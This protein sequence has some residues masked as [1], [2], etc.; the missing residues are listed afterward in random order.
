MQRHQDDPSNQ[1]GE[2]DDIARIA[3][4][5]GTKSYFLSEQEKN[6]DEWAE[7]AS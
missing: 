4:S 7:R 2:A 3:T 5:I 1:H 6:L